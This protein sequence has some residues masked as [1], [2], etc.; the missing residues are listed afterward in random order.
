ML[1]STTAPLCFDTAVEF[2]A[3][4]RS[5]RQSQV[6]DGRADLS[7][8][9]DCTPAYQVEMVAASRCA[10]PGTTF[11][12]WVLST[13]EIEFV[14]IRPRTIPAVAGDGARVQAP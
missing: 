1:T 5:A 14:G 4:M 6:R 12:K 2:A 7:F 9:T 11:R 10:F 13:G 3:W 8:C